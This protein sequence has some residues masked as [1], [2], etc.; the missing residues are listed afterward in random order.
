MKH[1]S[2]FAIVVFCCGCKPSTEQKDVKLYTIE[3][4]YNNK[5][6]S[7]ADFNADESQVL[8]HA[9]NTGIYNIYS[10]SVAD[11]VMKPL[12]HSVKDSYFAVGYVPRTNNF[13]YSADQGGNENSHIYLQKQGI[14]TV[15][16]ITPWP[17]STNSVAGWSDDKKYIYIS[18]NKRNPKFYDI[19]KLDTASWSP[20]LL[21][22]NDGGYFP[23]PI[24]HSERYITLNKLITTDKNELYIYDIQT[25]T[26]KRLS[27]DHEA[28]W[29]PQA[30]EKDDVALYYTTN[31]GNEFTYLVKYDLANGSTSKIYATKWDVTGMDISEHQKYHSIFINEDG[32]SKVLIFDHAT[33]KQLDF[34]EI[35]DGEIKNETFSSSEKNILLTV[36]SSRSPDNLY[37]Y[38]FEQ[39]TL[40]PITR[41]LNPEISTDELA[42]AEV[43]HFKSFD[44][45]TIPAIYYKPLNASKDHKV[46]AMLWIHGGP[47]G[48]S[49][50]SFSNQIQF[51]VNHGYAVLAVNNRGSSGYGK[52]FYKLDNKDHSN[53]DL[54][55]C[56]W[57][58]KWL[59]QQD[60]IDTAKIGIEGGSYGGCMVLGALAFHPEEFKVGVDLFGVANWIRT[61]RSIPP[62]W[63]AERKALYDE[64][65]D[66]YTADSVHL[67][68]ISPLFHYKTINKPLLVFQ[69][70]NDVRVLPVESKEIVE[71][72]KKNG[73]PVEYVTYPNE[74]H[75]FT[76]KEDQ[77]KTAKTT[78]EFLDKYLNKK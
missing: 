50:T 28:T 62:Y 54:K 59:Q 55:D 4:L 1:L 22:Q 42:I 29:N 21:Y 72:V 71:G 5:A 76:K 9:N 46:P 68:K 61:L 38:N 37:V 19:Y 69:G 47:G 6:I 57:G 40:K 67:K 33:G 75:G 44:G 8:V 65:G 31:D 13:L 17:N 15:K 56:I 26:L 64:L 63:E 11:T 16:D 34:P 36:G 53:G 14:A 2:F 25:K 30:F 12:T 52:T 60:Y 78:L 45:L 7:G 58:K 70:L 27:S 10:I 32:K 3:Q 41:T 23:G 35:K 39:K 66:P 48:Q 51:L 49:N 18:S 73:V 20:T 74:G 24:S 43:V 77:I